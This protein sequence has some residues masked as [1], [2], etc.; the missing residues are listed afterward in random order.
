[1]EQ[2]SRSV[3]A[4]ETGTQRAAA[5]LIITPELWL[6]DAHPADIASETAAMRRL[7][8]AMATDHSKIFQV[9]VDLA[10]ELCQADTCGISLRER[11][12]TGEDIFRWIAMAG[13]LTEHLRGTTPR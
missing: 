12:D 7:A 4:G 3:A 13:Q 8:D 1:M 5:D 11:A 2:S 6:R 9:C 10:L